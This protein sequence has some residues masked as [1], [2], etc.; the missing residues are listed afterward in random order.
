VE[1]FPSPWSWSWSDEPRPDAAFT[2]AFELPLPLL[3][4]EPFVSTLM[5]KTVAEVVVDN[6]KTTLLLSN[7]AP[8]ARPVMVVADVS[9]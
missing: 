8:A 3:H 9:T 1:E 2:F 7:E 5:D 6:V 4:F